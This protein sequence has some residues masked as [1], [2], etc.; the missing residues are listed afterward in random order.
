M[1][2]N[3]INCFEEKNGYCLADRTGKICGEKEKYELSVNYQKLEKIKGESSY[4]NEIDQ[5]RN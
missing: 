1:C 2:K 4:Y 5:I 3:G